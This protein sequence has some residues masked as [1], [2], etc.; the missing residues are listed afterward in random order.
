MMN[1]S[2]TEPL[3]FSEDDL[4][5]G[6]KDVHSGNGLQ[7][8]FAYH[9]NVHNASIKIRMGTFKSLFFLLLENISMF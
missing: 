2:L 3:I 9:N 6:G 1:H 7:N 4:E 8:D 5:G